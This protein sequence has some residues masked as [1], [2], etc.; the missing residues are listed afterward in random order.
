MFRNHN[1][2]KG[3]F[4]KIDIEILTQYIARKILYFSLFL[5][6]TISIYSCEDDPILA[7]NTSDDDYYG[8]SYGGIIDE[9]KN[10]KIYLMKKNPFIF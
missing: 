6:L 3:D 2:F 9:N 10:Q 1:V 4:L 7:P 5:I 8:G